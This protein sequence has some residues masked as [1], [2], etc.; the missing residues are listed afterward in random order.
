L[1]F[2]TNNTLTKTNLKLWFK[3]F[4]TN[5]RMQ[6]TLMSRCR[7]FK[8]FD[9]GL[10][11]WPSAISATYCDWYL[12]TYICSFLNYIRLNINRNRNLFV[13]L[14]QKSLQFDTYIRYKKILPRY[15]FLS[16]IAFLFVLSAGLPDGIFSNQKSQFG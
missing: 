13:Q 9:Q 1:V 10:K 15:S 2:H 7:M 6:T 8:G 16:F 4:V 3:A 14:A 11:A 5:F 12:C